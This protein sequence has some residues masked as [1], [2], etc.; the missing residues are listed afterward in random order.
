MKRILSMFLALVLITTMGTGMEAAAKEYAA[1]TLRL[2]KTEGS[3]SVKNATGKEVSVKEG[4]RLFNGYQLKTGK[5]SYAW[6]SLDDSKVLKLDAAS[7]VELQKKDKDI[8]VYLKSGKLFFDVKEKLT[9]K[10]TMQIKTSTMVTGIRG[11][12]GVV[13]KINQN[14]TRLHLIEGKVEIFTQ[15]TK[16][17]KADSIVLEAGQTAYA[18]AGREATDK[19]AEVRIETLS[20]KQIPGFVAVE[21]K[22]D[23]TLQKRIEKATKLDV[24]KI[25]KTADEKLAVDKAQLEEKERKLEEEK[26]AEVLEKQITP[27]FGEEE[28]SQGGDGSSSSG[29]SPIGPSEPS[30]GETV[31]E[32]ER[33]YQTEIEVT[34]AEQLRAA[35]ANYNA[36][37]DFAEKSFDAE[38]GSNQVMT[39]S[40]ASEKLSLENK[41]LTIT[42]QTGKELK[43]N[44]VGVTITDVGTLEN[45]GTLTLNA[46]M[47]A[48]SGSSIG[49]SNGSY[50][51]ETIE[52]SGTMTMQTAESVT[53]RG[54]VENTGT[55]QINNSTMSFSDAGCL[56]NFGTLT[57]EN[58]T[59][60]RT[61]KSSDSGELYC[62]IQNDGKLNENESEVL[63][64]I[65]TITNSTVKVS[66]SAKSAC[67]FNLLSGSI[68]LNGGAYIVETDGEVEHII[69]ADQGEDAP[70]VTVNLNNA[71][72]FGMS[73]SDSNGVVISDP[74]N[75][76]TCYKDGNKVDDIGTL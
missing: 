64:G 40:V 21:I 15:S 10:E 25:I 28:S 60:S 72:E 19:L 16:D 18:L 32:P 55:L 14:E 61:I 47:D 52:N 50:S 73:T 62:V 35:I 51:F 56:Y 68:T 29:G 31:D 2:E 6:L 38:A 20:E 67:V 65:T 37:N 43:I 7:E 33:V 8:V 24:E 69:V 11:T 12:C 39:I 27:L 4:S 49:S 44:S 74:Y 70:D 57:V 63:G 54:S 42:E 76:V 53:I 36:G 17:Q 13:E 34:T 45:A 23:I 75:H 59:I 1:S 22:K 41:G 26:K 3:V 5:N 48:V 30:N 58:S 9:S 46:G 66:G 71:P